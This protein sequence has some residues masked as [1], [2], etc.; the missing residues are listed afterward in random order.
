[1]WIDVL[2]FAASVIGLVLIFW[3]IGYEMNALLKKWERS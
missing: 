2:Q 1:M 3:A